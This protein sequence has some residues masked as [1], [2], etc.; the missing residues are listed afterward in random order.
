MQKFETNGDILGTEVNYKIQLQTNNGAFVDVINETIKG[1]SKDSYSREHVINL[2]NA[3]FGTANYT[4]AKIKVVR[5]TADSNVDEIQDVFIVSRVEE[6]VYTP[7]AYP[8]LHST[9]RVSAEQFRAVPQRAFR[10][11]GI[12]VN[13]PGAGANNSGTP[14]VDIAT[15]RIVYPANYIFNGTM[16]AAVWTTCPSMILLDLLT[17]QRYG[18]GVHISPDFDIDNPSDVD[19]FKN[20]DLF[21]Y[22]QASRYANEEITLDDGTKEARFACNV[23]YREQQKLYFINELSGIMRAFP[24]WPLFGTI[25]QDD[26]RI[27]SIYFVGS[28]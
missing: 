15:G 17:N 28:R 27:Q 5:V 23:A 19:L 8:V 16:G 20:I 2:P 14:T 25:T 3:I 13:I 26:H 7:Q 22:V 9:L 4:Q 11:R 21:S 10:I 12:K 18:L 1:R 6:I 24:I